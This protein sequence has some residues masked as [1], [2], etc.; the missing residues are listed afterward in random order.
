MSE[1][2]II[3]AHGEGYK[4]NAREQ[5]ALDVLMGFSASEKYLPSHY[6]YDERGSELFS[7][8]TDT[9]DYY[10]TRCEFEIFEAHRSAISDLL[11][12]ERFNLIELGAGD[13]R[14]TRLLLDEFLK[15]KK[16]L[17]DIRASSI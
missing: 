6:L 10:P 1:Y 4:V 15:K 11:R 12:G 17:T 16:T 9:D 7:K 5:F 2:T 13:G 14:K 3:D 8:I